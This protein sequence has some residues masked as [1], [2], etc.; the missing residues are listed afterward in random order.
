MDRTQ[1]LMLLLACKESGIRGGEREELE[2]LALLT[3]GIDSSDSSKDSDH[4]QFRARVEEV[5][6][7]S[8]GE[9]IT[10]F[11]CFIGRF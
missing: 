10:V 9:R 2:E 6:T 11:E 8:E 4:D 3:V 5:E 7:T 1:D